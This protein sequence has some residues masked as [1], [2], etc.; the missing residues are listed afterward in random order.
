[1]LD[2]PR[3]WCLLSRDRSRSRL[4]QVSAVMLTA[5]FIVLNETAVAQHETGRD[6]EDGGRVYQSACAY[7]HG[8]DGD[9]IAGI[10]FGRGLY[11]RPL[12]DAE[13]VAIVLAGIPNSPMPPTPGMSEEQAYRVVAYL[14]AMNAE[15]SVASGDPERGRALFLGQGN[16][17]ECHRVGREG[18]R[19]G[20]DLSRI[21]LLRRAIELEQS[22]LEP[23]AE[24]QPQNRVYEVVARSGETTIGRLLSH[25][26]FTVQ[27]I[28]RDERLR[29]FDKAEL[30]AHGF[31]ASPM[32]SY[33]DELTAQQVADLVSFL[34][35]LLGES[36]L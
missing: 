18:S 9:L 14:R 31:V 3:R 25:D 13:I 30:A 29:S 21:G 35:S 10:D 6:I 24:I 32:P 17:I 33:R 26:T 16:C 22:L 1:M 20:P 4:V 15:R 7:C 5:G 34:S 19:F 36:A 27:L 2:F 12:T 28:D 11:R 23:Q 8:P